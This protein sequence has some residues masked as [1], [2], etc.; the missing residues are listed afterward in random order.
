MK[1][2]RETVDGYRE[3]DFM[4]IKGI[5]VSA[6]QGY[7]DWKTVAAY[8]MGFAIL[9]V[10]EAGN[11][12]DSTFEAN[13]KG[14]AQYKIPVGVY[15]YSYAMTVE[16]SRAEAEKVISVLKGKKLQFPVFLDLEWSRQRT[17]G[18][19]GVEKIAEAFE[20]IITDAG[21]RF[22]IY[23]NVDWYHTMISSGLKKYDFWIARYPAD[24]NGT[25]KERLRP[26]FGVGWQYS[27]KATIPG[28]SGYV[29][30]DVFYKNYLDEEDGSKEEGENKNEDSNG[31]KGEGTTAGSGKI[32][33]PEEKKNEDLDGTKGEEATASP[34]ETGENRNQGNEEDQE[35]NPG[36]WEKTEKLLAEQTG[37]LEKKSAADLDSKNGN[38]GYGNY[39]KYARDVNGW[40][41]PGYQGQPWCAVYQFWICVNVFGRE[42]ALEIM[43]GGF[44]NCNSVRA[45]AKAKGTWH[46]APRL[47]ALVNFRNGAHMGRVIR[48][49]GN[50]IYTNE[51]NTSSGNINHVEA[52][53]G[54]VA[55][56]SYTADNSQIDGYVWIDYGKGAGTTEETVW[57]PAGTATSTVDNL[58]VRSAPAGEVLG[59]LM[60]GNRFE[61]NGAASG[62]WIQVNVA[63]IGV[64][65][66]WSAY[67][68]KDGTGSAEHQEDTI[69]HKQDKRERLFVGEVTAS[70][71]NV[72]T[73]AGTEYPQ[74]RSYPSLAKGNLVD[75]MNFTQKAEDGSKWYY[76]R[77]AGQYYGFV[78]SQY[79]K[80]K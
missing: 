5:D 37:Y 38:A 74:I 71:L 47:G 10:T 24:D 27:S 60:K 51:G 14:C 40:G 56:K 45:H 58:Y 80:R 17:L 41:L 29:D 13:Y 33:E 79:I 42:K 25:L 30:R 64:G 54:S 34:G 4:E 12:A 8:G 63:N 26:D 18:A 52:N 35:K 36:L 11:V 61:I 6:W 23:C 7:I 16:E 49:S 2:P 59:E 69:E 57:K 22:G 1:K 75:V 76:I 67:I 28:I 62:S 66:V 73:W 78:H 31:T 50:V 55:E 65:W 46:T 53:G 9:R 20:K 32:E 15:K 3:G 72:R 39:T 21:Y 77:I 48:I 19:S 43:G 70:A 44:Y 68:K